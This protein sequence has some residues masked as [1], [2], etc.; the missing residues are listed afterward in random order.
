MP[1]NRITSYDKENRFRQT[2][3]TRFYD[4]PEGYRLARIGDN[5]C[6]AAKVGEELMNFHFEETRELIYFSSLLP[7]QITL[8]YPILVMIYL[9]NVQ[10]FY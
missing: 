10:R 4:C 3:K 7:G 9:L 5:F 1:N 2:P 8:N 6:L